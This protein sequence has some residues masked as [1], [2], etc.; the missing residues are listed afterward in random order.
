MLTGTYYC[1]CRA[2]NIK[3]TKL[4]LVQIVI[5]I[6]RTFT[7]SES[8]S[9]LGKRGTLTIWVIGFYLDGNLN[10]TA[11]MLRD[12][13]VAE[14]SGRLNKIY[15]MITPRQNDVDVY[16]SVTSLNAT[17]EQAQAT[18]QGGICTYSINFLTALLECNERGPSFQRR[19]SFHLGKLNLGAAAILAS[20]RIPP[21]FLKLRETEGL[22]SVPPIRG[23][24]I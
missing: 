13:L 21:H 15:H 9:V 11:N 17:G 8:I 2:Q 3:L 22:L 19:S 14:S 20:L 16:Q 1:G 10:L 12:N 5:L 6:T 24:K 23:P 4:A 7:R 18:I